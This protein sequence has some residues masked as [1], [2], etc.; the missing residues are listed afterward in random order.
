[1][2]NRIAPI[3][4]LLLLIL[5]AAA[6]CAAQQTS[7]A[8]EIVNNSG[9]ASD[10]VYILLTGTGAD[11]NNTISVGV[12]TQLSTLTASQFTLNAISAGR[13][14]FSFNGSVPDNQQP[15][16]ASPRF[17]KVELTY[18]GAANLTAVDFFGIP[19]KLETL[20][21]SSNVLQTLTFYTSTT[22]L[23]RTLTA[24]AS[25][26]AIVTTT[27]VSGG[28]FARLLSPEI[29]P[30]SYPSMQKYVNSIAGQNVTI[31][32]T[33]M[34]SVAPS[35]N[36]YNYSGTFA[37]NGTIV[38]SGTMTQAA[39]PDSQPLTV[40]GASLAS[41]IYTNNGNYTVQNASNNPQQVANDDVYAAIY[42][43]L[44]AGF[45]FGYLGGKYG[46]NSSSWYGTTPYNQPYA[47]ARNTNDGFF[48]QYAS[49][50]AANSDAYGFPFSDVNQP[51]QVALNPGGNTSVATLRITILP[52]GMLDAPIIRSASSTDDSI[53]VT[54]AS[55][56]GATGYMV[57]VSPPIPAVIHDA[58]NLT[59]YTIPDLNSGTPYTISVIASKGT[60][61]S[62]AMPVVVSTTGSVTPVPGT[63]AWNFVPNFT[64]TFPS[65]H[66]ITFNGVSQSLPATANPG[67]Q[68]NMVPG[69]PGQQNAYVFEWTDP[70]NDPVFSSIL[71][72]QLGTSSSNGMG[73][74]V[75]DF[76]KT[77]MAA[78][79]NTPTY[80]PGVA[81]NLFLSIAP[82]AQRTVYAT[83]L[84]DP[85]PTVFCSNSNLKV[86]T[87]GQRVYL[88]GPITDGDG[89]RGVAV[90]ATAKGRKITY[91]TKM[92]CNRWKATVR[93]FGAAKL[94]VDVTAV[95]RKG[96]VKT[97]RYLVRIPAK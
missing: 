73:S 77:F 33:Y 1:M 74:I 89:L 65:G 86:I 3:A 45:S 83:G 37:T 84:T 60:S 29:S 55:T 22:S 87:K 43:D 21:A 18:P 57:Q 51:V 16:V 53:T 96:N 32:G 35:N 19:F 24:L 20:D 68:F 66:T 50:I 40:D 94:T 93:T 81:F 78:N 56:S 7:I 70:N 76:S 48:N 14:Y 27:G 90:T 11:T 54:W 92:G 59:S 71:Y 85:S 39:T 47:R 63:V 44:I 88:E 36:S 38:L 72:V 61:T 8:V 62:E 91:R 5:A 79:Q 9:V 69:V 49:I 95:D 46:S 30:S 97:K 58:G 15:L 26:G 28:P 6:P 17:D 64:G 52:D 67:M 42:R 12:P 4:A 2:K 34:G 82:N 80:A 23:L 25:P 31:A 10:Q 13:I 75:Q 41:A